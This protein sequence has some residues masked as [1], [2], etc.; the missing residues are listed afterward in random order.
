MPLYLLLLLLL[1]LDHSFW[2]LLRFAL[3]FAF[4]TEV[5]M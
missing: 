2:R 1:L 4:I 3:H 5:E